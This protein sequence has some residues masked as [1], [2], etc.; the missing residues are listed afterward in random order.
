MLGDLAYLIDEESSLQSE[1]QKQYKYFDIHFTPYFNPCRTYRFCTKKTQSC[2][3]FISCGL[4]GISRNYCSCDKCEKSKYP[5]EHKKFSCSCKLCQRLPDSK[6]IPESLPIF[7]R[8]DPSNNHHQ[9]GN[10]QNRFCADSAIFQKDILRGEIYGASAVATHF[11]QERFSEEHLKNLGVDNRLAPE[12]DSLGFL[13]NFKGNLKAWKEHKKIKKAINNF[14]QRYHRNPPCFRER[15]D[16]MSLTK[17][18]A[19]C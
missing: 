2:R 13:P 12:F 11:A 8:L 6:A 17:V 9:R 7:R 14:R 16:I 4:C 15:M 3:K 1:R 19:I 18:S 5:C 10:P